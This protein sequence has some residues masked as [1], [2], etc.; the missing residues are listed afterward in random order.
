MSSQPGLLR[1]ADDTGVPLLAARL[2][3]GVLFVV[4]GWNKIWDPVGFLKLI[5][6]YQI[7]GDSS[8]VLL[9]LMAVT[10]PAI[11]MLCGILLIAGVLIRGA[12]LTLFTMLTGFTIV[13]A[14]RT[15]RIHAGGAPL[16]EIHFDCGCGGGDVYMCWKI[17]ENIGLW[18]LSFVALVSRSRRFCLQSAFWRQPDRPPTGA[19]TE[20]A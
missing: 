1:R 13:L 10:I 3:L 12:A 15:W 18:L 11:E 6:E 9:N 4:M 20:P 19:A 17:P 7:V 8:Y 2:V 14:I 5:H 16:C